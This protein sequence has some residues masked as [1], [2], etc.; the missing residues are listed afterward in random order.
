LEAS[1]TQKFNLVIDEFQEFKQVNNSIF[2]DMQKLWDQYRLESH[3]N[4]VLCGSVSTLIHTIFQDQKEPLFGRAD[5]LIRIKPFDISTQRA[6]LADTKPDYTNE[7]LLALY[8]VTG[9]V[10]KYIELFVD[11]DALSYK[12]MVAYMVREDS[13]F[14]DEGRNLLVGEFGKNHLGYFSILSALSNGVNQQNQIENVL[15]GMSVGGQLKRLIE[16]YDVIERKRPLLSKTN[17][18]AVRY[19][20]VDNFIQYWFNYFDRNQAL[21]E[22]GNFAELRRRILRDYEGYSRIILE[23]YFKQKLAE[24]NRYQAIGS[25]WEPKREQYA[26]D[27]LAL[28]LAKNS[29]EVIEVKRQKKKFQPE[30]LKEK[31]LHLQTKH[32]HGFTVKEYCL[33]IEDM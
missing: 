27:I 6:I 23:R 28:P 26:I 16:D 9:G 10:A 15:G 2:S 8:T 20:I 32:L 14:L 29:A 3:M 13:L 5:A 19:E 24:S 21:I 30:Q 17:T 25:W 33:S 1:K 12:D 11:N 22:I 7:D 31:S 18:Q 4:L